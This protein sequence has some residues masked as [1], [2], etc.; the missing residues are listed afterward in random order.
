MSIRPTTTPLISVR[1]PTKN[2][3]WLLRERALASVFYQTYP[4]LEIVVVG[5]NCTDDTER[6]VHGYR[7]GIRIKFEN[8]PPREKEIEDPEMRWLTGPVRA[9]NRATELCTGEWIAHLDDDDIWTPD[10]V[11]KMYW[12]ALNYGF[13]FVSSAYINKSYG[14]FRKIEFERID[15]KPIGGCQTW[16]Y[17]TDIARQFPYDEQCYKK[18]HNRVSDLDVA[19]RIVQAGYKVGFLDEV[20]AYVLPRPGE[21][22]VGLK[23]YIK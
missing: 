4:N 8:L 2:R 21:D 19:E 7:G 17:K 3:E 13:D 9:T 18:S 16:L 11:E 6:M 15:G 10:H 1:I 12:F 5:D 14:Q 22:T 23:A 20:H